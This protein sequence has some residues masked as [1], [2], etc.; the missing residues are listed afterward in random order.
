M[1]PL[2]VLGTITL[3]L[4][5]IAYWRGGTALPIA[6]ATEAFRIFASVAP[7]LALG[8]LL[9][10]LLTVLVPAGTIAQWIGAESGIQGVLIATI[11]GAL[12]PGGPYM[13]FPLVAALAGAGAGPGPM[14]AYLAAWSLVSVN[15]LLVWEIP[16]LGVQFAAVR[17]IVSLPMP[18]VAGIVVPVVLRAVGR[19]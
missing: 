5:T 2:L 19:G 7:Q 18:I 12:T 11:A 8:F 17:W 15:R 1:L 13:Q 6:G 14:A 4:A 16:I 10:G 3:L 9:A